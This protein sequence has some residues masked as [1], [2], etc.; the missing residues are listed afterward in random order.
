[1]QKIIN[2]ISP[3]EIKRI[4]GAGNK[5]NNLAIGN[6]DCYLHPSPGLKFWDLCAPESLMK[7]MGGF[8]TD[9]KGERIK[10]VA[11]ADPNLKG[12]ILAKNPTWH[13]T[14]TERLGPEITNIYNSVFNKP[15]A[16]PKVQAPETTSAKAAPETAVVAEVKGEAP[17]E[18]TK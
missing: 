12:L 11:G 3:V 5:C 13:K 8:G 10:Y 14:I 9:F 18:E 15:K 17:K 2:G 7:G 6:V 16:A 4:G 1:M